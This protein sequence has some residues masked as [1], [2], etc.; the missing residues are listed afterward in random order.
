MMEKSM[1]P[2]DTHISKE[3][4]REHAEDNTKPT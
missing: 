2:V 4:E 1:N 3:E